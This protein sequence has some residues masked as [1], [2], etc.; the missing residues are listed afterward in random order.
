MS[1]A[2]YGMCD[3]C[4]SPL[5]DGE[6]MRGHGDLCDECERRLGELLEPYGCAD[7]DDFEVAS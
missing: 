2:T 3:D 6:M 7:E 5:S 1:R 4:G